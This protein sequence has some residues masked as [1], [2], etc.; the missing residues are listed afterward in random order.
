M[1]AD[2]EGRPPRP[3]LVPMAPPPCTLSSSATRAYIKHMRGVW[4]DAERDA[5]AAASRAAGKRPDSPQRSS[6]AKGRACYA[7]GG[8]AL[9]SAARQQRTTTHSLDTYMAQRPWERL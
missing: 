8:G 6:P 5:E 2:D 9:A 1:G 7:A 4:A 3:D